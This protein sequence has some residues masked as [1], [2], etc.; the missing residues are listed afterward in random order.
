MLTNT[1]N[2]VTAR[3]ALLLN[4]SMSAAREAGDGTGLGTLLRNAQLDVIATGS[5]VAEKVEG[6]YSGVSGMVYQG[7]LT[8]AGINALVSPSRGQIYVATDGGNTS[9]GTPVALTAGDGAEFDG[10]SWQKLWDGVAGVPPVGTVVVVGNGTLVSPLTDAT[11]EKK[12]A[13]WDGLSLTPTLTVPASGDAYKVTNATSVYYGEVFVKNTTWDSV[14]ATAQAAA[15]SRVTNT[16]TETYYVPT[17]VM[18]TGNVAAGDVF[19]FDVVVNVAGITGTP[20]LTT[21]VY[22]GATQIL[23]TGAVTVIADDMVHLKGYFQ[24][25]AVGASG[26]VLGA[27]DIIE[28]LDT[29]T[30]VESELISASPDFSADN[31]FRVSATWSAPS[32]SNQ[33]DLRSIMLR[34]IPSGT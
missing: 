11:D 3:E 14:T 29:G 23:T 10:T 12:V 4:Q 32:A 27:A 15:V 31:A 22:I 33:S 30:V 20:T 5:T 9:A 21:K 7:N 18:P 2:T 19:E 25:K 6:T 8:V 17:K 34:R 1:G 13:T 26:S 24:V 16:T 28:A